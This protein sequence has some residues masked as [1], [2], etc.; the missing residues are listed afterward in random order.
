MSKNS[1][2]IDPAHTQ[3]EFGVKHMM[4]TTV[5]GQFSE[6]EGTV[7]LNEESPEEPSVEVTIDAASIDTGVQDRDDHLRSG[8]FFDVERF[9]EITFRS[10]SVSGDPSEGGELEIVGD[11]TIRDVTRKVTLEGRFEGT[12]TD[13]W[14]GSRAGFSATTEIDRRDFDLTWNQALETGGVLVGHD[15]SITLQVQAV[16]QEEPATV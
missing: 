12:G 10:T 8:D 16:L 13:P 2:A 9:P 4:F 11:L 7:H 3:V 15:I 6:F 1:W 14:G 5:R